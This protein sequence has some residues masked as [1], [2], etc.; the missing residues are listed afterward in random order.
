MDQQSERE[1]DRIFEAICEKADSTPV[2]HSS[3]DLGDENP[4]RAKLIADGLRSRLHE[5]YR[6]S[7]VSV[8]VNMSNTLIASITHQ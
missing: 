1:V 7:V 5:R 4:A 3:V 8:N 6:S 2:T